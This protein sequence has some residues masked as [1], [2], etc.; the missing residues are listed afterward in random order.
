MKSE[1]TITELKKE[2][3]ELKKQKEMAVQYASTK[4]EKEKLLMEIKELNKIKNTPSKLQNIKNGFSKFG[5]SFGRGLSIVWK[6]IGKASRNIE[7]RDTEL[8]SLKTKSRS[9]AFSPEANMWLPRVPK[10]RTKTIKTYIPKKKKMKVK[11]K[12]IPKRPMTRV[13]TRTIIK[14]R[15]NNLPVFDLP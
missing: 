11:V 2:I 3:E 7:S 13:V 10:S 15:N 8:K 5:S 6:E 9:G 4:A 14:N 12:T 1:P